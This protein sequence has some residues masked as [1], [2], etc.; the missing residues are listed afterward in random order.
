MKTV[1]AILLT[2]LIVGAAGTGVIYY[3]KS[4]L[5]AGI[6]SIN[7]QLTQATTMLREK[8]QEIANLQSQLAAAQA[9]AGTVVP[10]PVATSGNDSISINNQAAGSTVNVA[11]VFLSKPGFI[12]IHN[13][14]NGAPGAVIG[15]SALLPAGQSTNILVTLSANMVVGSS[16]IAMLHFDNGD[17]V[18]TSVDEDLPVLDAAGHPVMMTFNA[19]SSAS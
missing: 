18:Y 6:S 13:T 7:A 19:L 12:A 8:D 11:S 15:Y 1:I 3:Q 17:G 16:Y 5:D 14:V 9:A 4:Q 10:A 2:A